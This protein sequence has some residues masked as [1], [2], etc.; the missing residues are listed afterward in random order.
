MGV[1]FRDVRVFN[2]ALLVKQV[3]RI[4]Q[5]PD[6]LVAHV[7]K[8]KYFPDSSFIEARVRNRVS[9]VWR[10]ILEGRNVLVEG[11]RWRVGNGQR[12]KVWADY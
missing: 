7:L 9:Y 4:F 8:A 5:N 2:C 12:I 6:S 11:L 10:S 1:S 3:C